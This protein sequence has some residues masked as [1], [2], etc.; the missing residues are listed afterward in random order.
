MEKVQRSFGEVIKNKI[1]VRKMLIN[2]QN[3]ELVTRT[4][5]GHT[6]LPITLSSNNWESY[7]I[8]HIKIVT[9]QR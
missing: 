5:S 9:L 2:D 7:H 4:I 1:A 8:F 6:G 3:R